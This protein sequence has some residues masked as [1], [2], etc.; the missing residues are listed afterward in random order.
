MSPSSNNSPLLNSFQVIP[1]QLIM[2]HVLRNELENW[3]SKNIK[4]RFLWSFFVDLLFCLGFLTSIS[5][6]YSNTTKKTIQHDLGLGNS[7]E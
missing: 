3:L 6:Y 1:A 7:R 5:I 4:E 2:V